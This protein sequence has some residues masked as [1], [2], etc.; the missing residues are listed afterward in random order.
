MQEYKVT[1][2]THDAVFW[3]MYTALSLPTKRCLFVG[4]GGGGGGGFSLVL[5]DI[6]FFL[7]TCFFWLVPNGETRKNRSCIVLFG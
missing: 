5:S 7:D 3:N 4:T 1:F 6:W 2:H